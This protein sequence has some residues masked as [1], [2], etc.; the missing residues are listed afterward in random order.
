MPDYSVQLNQDRAKGIKARIT[1][2]ISKAVTQRMT[3]AVEDK[4]TWVWPFAFLLAAFNDLIDLGIIGSIPIIGDAI[5]VIV[6]AILFGFTMSLGGHI[7][8]KIRII[9]SLAGLFELIPFVDP[10]PTWV[11]SIMWGWYIT[12]KKGQIAEEGL[13]KLQG[14]VVDKRAVAEFR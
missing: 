7:R 2:K 5:D 1:A 12:Q 10:I 13:R 3:K 4:Q 14:G 6:W 11:F 9:I 8:L